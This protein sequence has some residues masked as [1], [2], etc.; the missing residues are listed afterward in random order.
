MPER[1]P[2]TGF[3][4]V[5]GM[6]KANWTPTPR[7]QFV[8]AYTGTRQDGADRYDQLLG[9]D[10]NLIA[11]LNDMRLDLFYA[12]VERSGIGWFNHGTATYSVNSQREERVNQ[13]G[14]GSKTATIGHEPERTTSQA[15]Q[16]SLT[17]TLSPKASLQIGGDMQFE[18]LTSDA[19]NVNPVT[20]A[21]P[22]GGRACRATPPTGKAARGRKRPS[23]RPARCASLARCAWGR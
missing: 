5:A 20:Q 19:F 15:V 3:Q 17:R 23:T 10:G 8:T 22:R 4:Q 16:G 9:G 18:K 14:N 2:D 1:L 6:V 11:E 12:R 13:G 21:S 7:T